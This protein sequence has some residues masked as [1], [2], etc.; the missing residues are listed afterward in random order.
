MNNI[1]KRRSVFRSSNKK[2][3]ENTSKGQ[4]FMLP[5]SQY[6]DLIKNTEELQKLKAQFEKTK[7]EKT[8]C[9]ICQEVDIIFA[10]IAFGH[11]VKQVIN[12]PIVELT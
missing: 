9:T 4:T 5:K 2:T 12:A 7:V 1:F 6:L 8:N 11:G 3:G 10:R